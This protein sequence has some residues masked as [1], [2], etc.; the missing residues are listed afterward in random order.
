MSRRRKRSERQ[1]VVAVDRKL[2]GFV[3]AVMA[4]IA[5]IT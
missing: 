5:G 1:M 2:R 4:G 3:E